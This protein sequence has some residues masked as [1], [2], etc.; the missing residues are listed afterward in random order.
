M[1]N[2]SI[3]SS[4]RLAVGLG[5]YE[6]AFAEAARFF[7]S[8]ARY[9]ELLQAVL[10][11]QGAFNT[12]KEQVRKGAISLADSRAANNAATDNLLEIV[13]MAERGE[14]HFVQRVSGEAA[15]KIR[16]QYFVIGGLATLAAAFFIWKYVF[17]KQP[18]CPEWAA[19]NSYRVMLLPFKQI[20]ETAK[21]TQPEIILMDEL[22]KMA[23][24]N[25][26]SAQFDANEFYD[27]EANYPST[28]EAVALA[29]TCEADMIIWGKINPPTSNGQTIDVKFKLLDNGNV[30]VSGDTTL[31]IFS[32]GGWSQNIQNISKFLFAVLANRLDRPDVAIK[33]LNPWISSAART[34]DSKTQATAPGFTTADTSLN[35]QMGMAFYQKGE[36]EAA[37]TQFSTALATNPTNLSVLKNR[38]IAAYQAKDFEGAARDFGVLAAVSAE[39]PSEKM[40]QMR[41]DVF[42][43]TNRLEPAKRDLD[44]LDSMAT[45]GSPAQKKWL[46]EKKTEFETRSTSVEK[47]VKKDDRLAIRQPADTRANLRAGRSNLNAGDSEKAKKYFQKVLQTDP[48]NE[49][50]WSG[51]IEAAIAEGGQA[52]A[53]KVVEE[54]IRTGQLTAREVKLIA[55]R[56]APL[57]LLIEEKKQ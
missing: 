13:S 34:G 14:L 38:G 15:H 30:R 12:T 55:P 20:D 43:K 57:L 31:A 56:A 46:A 21:K 53:K 42:L 18:T 52:E 10:L 7:D 28:A 26:L 8:D 50:A 24:R 39:K 4:I 49:E 36:F 19:G 2:E 16:W 29:K 5:E 11:N 47:Q 22:E 33:V 3:F 23:T 32:E 54:A 40:L 25:G 27:I 1:E 51:K 35:L 44:A 45:A 37:Q 48:K 17:E 6:R 9:S 41:A